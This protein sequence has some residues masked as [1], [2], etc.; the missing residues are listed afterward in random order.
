MRRPSDGAILSLVA[1]DEG[2][3]PD[4][5]LSEAEASRSPREAAA[6][7]EEE[8]DVVAEECPTYVGM[9]DALGA[10]VEDAIDRLERQDRP[11]RTKRALQQ[12]DE[13]D[14]YPELSD[15]PQQR[16]RNAVRP[17]DDD[18]ASSPHEGGLPAYRHA[19][20]RQE[21]APRVAKRVP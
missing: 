12:L 10:S 5:Q 19:P 6:A 2:A 20:H 8:V 17:D 15:P 13:D 21:E 4:E 18:R 14:A 7:P 1:T 16:I 9:D 3:G 11:R